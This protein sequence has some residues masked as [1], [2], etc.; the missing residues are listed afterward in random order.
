MNFIFYC[1]KMA[2]KKLMSLFSTQHSW[3]FYICHSSVHNTTDNFIQV[4]LQYTTWLR[5]LHV[6]FQYTT[7][8]RIFYV[9]LCTQHNWKFYICHS[10]VYNRLRIPYM[11]LF[12]IQHSWEFSVTLQYATQLRIL[13][14]SLFNIKHNWE[15][16]TSLFSIQHS[17]KFYIC[18]SSVYSTTDNSIYVNL[19]YTTQLRIFCHSSV[20]NRLRILD[21]SLFLTL[22]S[23]E[24][25]MPL[26]STVHNSSIQSTAYN[27][28]YVIP[29]HTKFGTGRQCLTL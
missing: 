17:W 10:L 11:S 12:S 16:Y 22:H 24:F 5:I 9:T 14:M 4:T 19:Q 21:M 6:T 15:F 20:Y 29:Q 27:S 23:W 3:E 18:H 25:S 28:I 8:L 7:Q 1:V 26:Y 2:V 13:Y